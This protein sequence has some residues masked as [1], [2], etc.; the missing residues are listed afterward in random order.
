MS[1][2]KRAYAVEFAWLAA[3]AAALHRPS[4]APGRQ[5]AE[6]TLVIYAKNLKESAGTACCKLGISWTYFSRAEAC[7]T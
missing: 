1:Q 7:L 4:W 2:E 6:R 5:K 3:Q